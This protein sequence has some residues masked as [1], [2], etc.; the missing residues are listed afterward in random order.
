MFPDL[1]N[2][3]YGLL[4]NIKNLILASSYLFIYF[5][6]ILTF[7]IQGNSFSVQSLLF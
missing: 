4:D 5:L 2:Y 3:I 1:K 7:F 6:F